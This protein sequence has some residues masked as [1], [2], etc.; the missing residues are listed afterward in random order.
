[1]HLH[2]LEKVWLI[3]GIGSLVVFLTIISINAFLMGNHPPSH[4]GMLDPQKVKETAPFDQPGLKKLDDGTYEAVI[5][6]MAFGYQPAKLEIPVGAKV[7]FT[8]TSQDVIHSFTIP[9]TNV[10]L[11]LT[12]GHISTA[13]YTF[14]K[15]G[16]YLVICNE[17]CGS[18]HHVM[19]MNIEVIEK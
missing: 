9:S 16:S 1:M 10:N 11:M 3:F 13:E 17:Y 7:K 5:V 2:K 15:Q 19:K 14:T 18:G 6:A 4:M 8:L 12:P